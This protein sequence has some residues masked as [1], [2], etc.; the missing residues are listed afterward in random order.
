MYVWWCQA[1]RTRCCSM[2][3]RLAG[4]WSHSALRGLAGGMSREARFAH[5][6]V[7]RDAGVEDQAEDVVGSRNHGWGGYPTASVH[8]PPIHPRLRYSRPCQMA[9]RQSAQPV[10][11]GH[12]TSGLPDTGLAQPCTFGYLRPCA[13]GSRA[14]CS[15]TTIHGQGGRRVERATGPGQCR[16]RDATG[17]PRVLVGARERNRDRASREGNG[18]G[19][20]TA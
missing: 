14:G 15:N 1:V 16:L 7:P 8:H 18:R 9:A 3:N 19:R 6:V 13:G 4:V 17:T 20:G 2:C 11:E 10:K 12:R 5:H